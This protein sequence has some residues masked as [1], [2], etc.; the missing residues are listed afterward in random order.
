MLA[1]PVPMAKPETEVERAA[2]TEQSRRPLW[3][4]YGS[5][6]DAA[7]MELSHADRPTIDDAKS[8]V[9]QG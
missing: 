2:L 5:T 4:P 9:P 1:L 6:R 3:E 8:S 7:L